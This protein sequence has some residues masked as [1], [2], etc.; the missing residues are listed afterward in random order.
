MTGTRPIVRL[1]VLALVLA[2]L[3]T[4]SIPG[5]APAAQKHGKKAVTRYTN[6]AYGV[7][8]AYPKNFVLK[9]GDLNNTN[10]MGK[11]F[12]GSLNMAFAKDGG[13][14]IVTVEIPAGSY[15]RTDFV[16]AFFSVSTNQGLTAEQCAQFAPDQG[17]PKVKNRDLTGMRFE[18]IDDS[19]GAMGHQFAGKTYHGFS[20][21][22]CFELDYGLA[23]AGFGAV[24]GMKHVDDKAIMASLESILPTLKIAIPLDHIRRAA[25]VRAG[26]RIAAG[27]SANLKQAGGML[28]STH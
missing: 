11:G 3:A 14:R 2:G 28:V 18:G 25:S 21:G 27:E 9:E 23:T 8:F 26:A 19:E 13:V 17:F 1:C 20:T 10:D 22:R 5:Q 4:G 12:P 15:P 6:S 7:A 16:N 24:D